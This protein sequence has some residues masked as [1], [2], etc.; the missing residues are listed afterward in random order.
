MLRPSTNC[1]LKYAR[2]ETLYNFLY[3]N[4][5][6][7]FLDKGTGSKSSTAVGTDSGGRKSKSLTNF[8]QSPKMKLK[9]LALI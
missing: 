6:Y 5:S 2:I 1:L 3:S 9:L 8:E 4:V 7:T